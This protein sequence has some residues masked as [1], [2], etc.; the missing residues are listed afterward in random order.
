VLHRWYTGEGVAGS[1][2]AVSFLF[3][4]YLKKKGRSKPNFLFCRLTFSDQE[5]IF[6]GMISKKKGVH[7][8]KCDGRAWL[9]QLRNNAG[10]DIHRQN[11]N[12][13]K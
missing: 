7:L 9:T 1:K 6:C 13:E 8:E 4:D 5:K 2:E 11:Y 10:K 12:N 3:T